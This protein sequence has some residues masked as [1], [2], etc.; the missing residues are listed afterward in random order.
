MRFVVYRVLGNF[1]YKTLS[2]HKQN[3]VISAPQERANN[4]VMSPFPGVP[5]SFVK[6]FFWKKKKK[7]KK[8]GQVSDIAYL[9]IAYQ[10]SHIWILQTCHDT[11]TTLGLVSLV[12]VILVE[13]P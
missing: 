8:V 4:R 1:T 3:K 11:S 6:V 5:W 13:L 2:R 7:K 9:D 12:Q 10:I